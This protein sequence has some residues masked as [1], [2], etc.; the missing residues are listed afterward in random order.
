MQTSNS[1]ERFS[2]NYVNVFNRQLNF[3]KNSSPL[4]DEFGGKVRKLQAVGYFAQLDTGRIGCAL[5]T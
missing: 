2:S 1:I 4:H 3:L 5:T